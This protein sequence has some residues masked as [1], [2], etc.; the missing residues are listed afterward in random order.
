MEITVKI[1]NVYGVDRIYPVCDKA[2]LFVALTGNK[3]LSEADICFI[4][5]LG[6]SINIET[7]VI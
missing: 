7:P 2:R 5:S 6:Y 3:T 1:K 4:K